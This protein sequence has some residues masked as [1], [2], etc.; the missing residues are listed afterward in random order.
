[1]DGFLANL[2]KHIIESDSDEVNMTDHPLNNQ[3]PVL[4]VENFT[5][6]GALTTIWKENKQLQTKDIEQAKKQVG[7]WQ[8]LQT[9]PFDFVKA[10]YPLIDS[11]ETITKQI[12]R[13]QRGIELQNALLAHYETLLQGKEETVVVEGSEQKETRM[14]T[15]GVESNTNS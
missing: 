3:T 5:V 13:W 9:I 1:M 4:C 14:E 2:L 11:S 6:E 7:V 12:T 15:S 8:S 10:K